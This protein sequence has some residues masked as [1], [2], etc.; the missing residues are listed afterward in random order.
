[1]LLHLMMCMRRIWTILVLAQLVR[2]K[3]G[4]LEAIIL[5]A[6]AVDICTIDLDDEG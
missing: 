6:L 3:I 1:M 4:P 5:D 2:G